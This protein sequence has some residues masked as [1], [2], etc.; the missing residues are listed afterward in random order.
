MLLSFLHRV[1]VTD[2]V[3]QGIVPRESALQS[4]AC[5]CLPDKF[6]IIERQ[7][8]H[9][10]MSDCNADIRVWMN[11]VSCANVLGNE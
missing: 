1:F 2:D 5:A 11:I 4:A 8:K 6:S 3:L 9:M 10:P 7:I